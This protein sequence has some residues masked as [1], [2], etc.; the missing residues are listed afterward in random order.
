LSRSGSFRRRALCVL[1][2]ALASP[3]AHAGPRLFVELDYQP[4]STLG[5]CPSEPAFKAVI[6]DQLGYDPF[7]ADAPQ[8]IVARAHATPEGLRGTIEWRDASGAPRGERALSAEHSDCEA[9][10]RVMAFAIAVQIQLLSGEADAGATPSVPA[11]GA[12]RSSD[13]DRASD[14][15]A[16]PTKNPA[17]AEDRPPSPAVTSR[18][19]A[20]WELLLG[21]GPTLGFGVA[22]ATVVEGRVFGT[23]RHQRFSVEVGG[24]ASLPSR[25]TLAEGNGVEQQLL[26]GSLAGCLALPPLSG[27][28]VGK[29]GRLHVRGFGVDAPLSASGALAQIGPRLALGEE[30]GSRL[31]AALRLEALATL[32]PW[33]VTLNHREIWRTPALSL[34]VGA[35]LAVIFR[36]KP[37]RLRTI[38]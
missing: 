32:I 11:N 22:P 6:R 20:G 13:A 1:L 18:E 24:E 28:L 29:A 27:C 35:D 3:V 26:L 12:D 37:Q 33:G 15:S 4:D 9:F 2:L 34:S 14:T 31:A 25:R 17:S 8:T 36:N 19:P 7:R 16:A 5:D 10:A 30:L 38:P 23:L 21:V